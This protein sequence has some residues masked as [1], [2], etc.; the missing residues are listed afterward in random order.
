VVDD[1]PGASPSPVAA[2]EKKQRGCLRSALGVGVVLAVIAAAGGLGARIWDATVVAPWAWPPGPVLTDSWVGVGSSPSGRPVALHLDLERQGNG[3]G[4]VSGS[5][6]ASIAGTGAWCAGGEPATRVELEP[7]GGASRDADD[8]ELAP[9]VVDPPADGLLVGAIRGRFTG[10][11]VEVE[12]DLSVLEGGV[13]VSSG[14]LVDSQGPITM[15][16]TR[17]DRAA[18]E[19]TCGS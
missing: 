5:G 12:L 16:L 13:A 1:V 15:T 11:T 7:V 18:L 9:R 10:A 3:Q 2:P 17:G 6:R 8:I 14:D 4:F 19:V